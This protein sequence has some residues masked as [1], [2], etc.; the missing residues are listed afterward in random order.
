MIEGT[1]SFSGK[2]LSDAEDAIREA[3]RRIADGYTNGGDSNE[4]GQLLVPSER[5]E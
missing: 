3:L 5:R 1:I 4:F 2:T